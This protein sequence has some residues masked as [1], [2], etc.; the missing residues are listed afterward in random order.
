M[1]TIKS[2]T[3]GWKFLSRWIG[4]TEQT[5][6]SDRKTRG[7]TESIS[8]TSAAV[9]QVSYAALV[10]VGAFVVM[11]GQMTQGALIASSILGGRILAPV[12]ALPGLLVQYAH[13]KAAL[14]SL[15][16]LYALKTDHEDTESPLTPE[17][18]QGHYQLK[19]IQFAYGDNPPALAVSQ[20]VIHPGDR[21]AVL[22]PIG[23]GKS[24]LLRVLSG[25]YQPTQG[26]VLIDGLEISHIHRYVLNENIAYL[27]QDH[28]LFQGSLREN[29]LI[30]LPDPGDDTLI[31][32]MRKT[33]MDRFVA[34]HPKGL[35]RIITEGGKGLSGGQ[36]QLVAFTRLALF[37]PSIYL[38]DEPTATMDEEQ[39]KQC[40]QFLNQ[41][42]LKN[43]TMVIV[44][45]KPSIL[46]LVNRII[47]ITGNK[48]VMD[49]PRDLVM[50]QLSDQHA[51][52]AR[53][54]RSEGTGQSSQEA[55]A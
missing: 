9:Q 50:G 6:E 53:R 29:L 39:E 18:L 17:S 41:A 26:R 1:E 33:G 11:Q 21:I 47:V 32:A 46:P 40:L 43:K 38:L 37:D 13:A 31:Q 12:M 23:A 52:A 22:G 8:Y 5:I 35:A 7:A 2:G 30:G 28:R 44:T 49:G 36:K 54:N 55:M 16:R 34:S 15:E 25:M 4:V 24:S 45:H 48:I 20:L 14:E 10:V 42:A 19:D 27:Q 3:G 51:K